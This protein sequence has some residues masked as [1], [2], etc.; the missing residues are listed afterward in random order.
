[1]NKTKQ[2]SLGLRIWSFLCV[3]VYISVRFVLTNGEYVA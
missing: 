3:P 1:M 2:V